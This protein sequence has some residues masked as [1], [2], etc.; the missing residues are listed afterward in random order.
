MAKPD[1][2]VADTGLLKAARETLRRGKFMRQDSPEDHLVRFSIIE[3]SGTS[4][5]TVDPDWARAPSCSCYDH[6]Q[7]MRYGPSPW[8]RHIV[9]VMAREE[10]LRCQLIDLLL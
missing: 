10:E 5:V 3:R 4:T 2:E 7:S 6:W 9:A 8:C 1:M